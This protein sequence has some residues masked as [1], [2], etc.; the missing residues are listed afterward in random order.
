MAAGGHD[1]Q[2]GVPIRSCLHDLR[3]RVAETYFTRDVRARTGCLLEPL[4]CLFLLGNIL[5]HGRD[6]RI[7]RG[8]D[9]K[10]EQLCLVRNDTS[11]VERLSTLFAEVTG[12]ENG[13]DGLHNEQRAASSGPKRF[14]AHNRFAP[15]I[16]VSAAQ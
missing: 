14:P 13:V 10:P 9:V 16:R 4:Q 12:N 11:L 7:D 1:N 3:G 5:A 2:V 15:H 6:H 8:Q